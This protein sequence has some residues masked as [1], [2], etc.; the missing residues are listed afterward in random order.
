M[1]EKPEKTLKNPEKTLKNKEIIEN[2]LKYNKKIEK[3]E[4]FF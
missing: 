2:K 3:N 1:P 4:F